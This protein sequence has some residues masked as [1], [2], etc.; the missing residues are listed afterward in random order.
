M[1]RDFSD[2]KKGNQP[3]TNVVKDENGDLVAD[4][5]IFWSVGVTFYPAI[6]YAWG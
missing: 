4:C 6:K 3:G 2:F 1:Y 5:T